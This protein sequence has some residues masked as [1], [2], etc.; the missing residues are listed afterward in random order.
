MYDRPCYY[1]TFGGTVYNGAEEWQTGLRFACD[2]IVSQDSMISRLDQISVED[3]FGDFAAVI[4]NMVTTCQYP[5]MLRARWAKL[6]V[7]NTNGDYASAPKIHEGNVAGQYP[8][9]SG[10]APQ[11]A[12]AVTLGTGKKFGMAQK[13]R[14]YWPLP[15]VAGTSLELPTGQLPAQTARSFRDLVATAID[16]ATGEV[17]TTGAPAWPAVMSKSGGVTAPQAPGTTNRITEISVGRVIDTQRRRRSHL[18]E[19]NEIMPLEDAAA[20]LAAAEGIY[21]GALTAEDSPRAPRPP[22]G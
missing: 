18:Q 19:A 10:H 6:V 14:M 4:S 11:T 2:P 7:L 20:R 9:A 1:V 16:N 15:V 5:T 13:G 3:I 8:A 21:E 22:L 17:S 12:L